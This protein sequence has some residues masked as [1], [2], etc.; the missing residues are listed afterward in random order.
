[1][2]RSCCPSAMGHPALQPAYYALKPLQTEINIPLSPFSLE[3]EYFD[4]ARRKVT[5]THP[6][7]SPRASSL[8][9]LWIPH[10]LWGPGSVKPPR[11]FPETQVE[12]LSPSLQ[13][14]PCGPLLTIVAVGACTE[15]TNQVLVGCTQ[16]LWKCYPMFYL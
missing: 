11:S 13:C 4:S 16:P 8:S 9:C 14:C 12:T 7:F 5:K 2:A 3:L 1:M 10:P 6:V 15:V